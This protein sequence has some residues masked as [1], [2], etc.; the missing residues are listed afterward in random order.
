VGSLTLIAGSAH[1]A[2]ADA[3]AAALGVSLASRTVERFPDGE[4]RVEL[5]AD[6]RG[7][8]VYL[9]Q[10][11]G[12]PV[13]EHLL[14]LLMLADVAHRA[15][16][17]RI[18]AIIP[19]VGYARQD[20]RV[21]GREALGGRVVADLLG[22][23]SIE[24][25]IALDVHTPAL[26]GFFAMPLEHL[27]AVPLLASEL[28]SRVSGPAV[29]VA[30]D[31]G[32]VRLAEQYAT[33]L[34]LPAA[35]VVKS[36]VSGTEV[37]ATAVVGDVRGR[38]P[39]IID[40]MISTGGTVQAAVQALLAAGAVPPVLVAATHGL[41]VGPVAERLRS[42]APACVLVTDSLPPATLP[43]VPVQNI[44][45]APLLADT[46]RRLRVE[47]PISVGGS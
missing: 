15:G 47:A 19:Y 27:T 31:L 2:L 26:E 12:A 25:V 21:H 36:R 28:R 18:T 44:P 23:S 22:A 13:A 17:A 11:T 38:A 24:R 41:F 4:L 45:I 46:I 10:P 37:R 33:L 43:G 35:T 8:E 7:H 30:P 16:A 29:V 34:G 6:V 42:V 3:A 32:A 20:R 5:D 14:E 40:D 9:L 1:P 39:V